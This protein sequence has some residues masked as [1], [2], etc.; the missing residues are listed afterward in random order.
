LILRGSSIRNFHF[1][2]DGHE[3]EHKVMTLVLMPKHYLTFGIDQYK[4]KAI[5]QQSR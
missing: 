3:R 2:S 1:Y 4:I 5:G